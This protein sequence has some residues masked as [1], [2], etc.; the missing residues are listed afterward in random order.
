M[1]LASS[2]RP[3]PAG[4]PSR[5]TRAGRTRGHPARRR[6]AARRRARIGR[7]A[8]RSRGRAAT[9]GPRIAAGRPVPDEELACRRGRDGAPVVVGA[10]VVIGAHRRR[11]RPLR[12]G[13]CRSGARSATASSSGATPSTTRTSS[14]SSATTACCIVDTRISHRQADEI[15]AD[16]RELT[17]LPVRAVVNTHGHNDH[18]FGNHRFRPAPIWGHDALRARWSGRPASASGRR[19]RRRCRSS[20]TSSPRSSSIRPTGRSTAR[21]PCRSTPAGGSVELRYLGRGHTDNDIVVLVPDADVLLR[22]R[23]RRERRDAVL[24]R[25][26]PDR[27]AGDGRAHG[28][29]RDRRRRARPRHRR[30]PR[31][32]PSAR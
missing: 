20:P 18:A 16:L 26:L 29:A 9:D 2:A 4:R 21:R 8:R 27:L 12:C 1:V 25:R 13:P 5:R 32:S 3:R 31:R 23:P 28:R 19:S 14:P 6:R 24:R 11:R 22:R 10:D 17:P 7:S 30:R 15:L